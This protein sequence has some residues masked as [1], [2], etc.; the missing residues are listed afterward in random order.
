MHLKTLQFLALED[1]M[2][3]TIQIQFVFTMLQLYL[4]QSNDIKIIQ[5]V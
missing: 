5:T 2:I 1:Q 4:S 3:N